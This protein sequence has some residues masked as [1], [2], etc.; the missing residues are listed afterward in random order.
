MAVLFRHLL[1]GVLAIVCSIPGAALAAGKPGAPI[2]AAPGTLVRWTA[3]GTTRCSM[4][5]RT[6]AALQETCYYPIDLLQ[7]PGVIAIA[8]VISGRRELARISVGPS[9]TRPRRSTFP[10]FRKPTPRRR[11]SSVTRATRC[12]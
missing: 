1:P 4:Q 11:T 3:P 9:R 6:W 8:R 5:G 10:T 12:S 2:T 7:K